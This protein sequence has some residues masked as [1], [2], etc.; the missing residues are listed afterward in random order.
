MRVSINSLP[1]RSTYL[2]SQVAGNNRP[3]YPKVDH[4]WLKVAHNNYEP[5]ALQVFFSGNLLMWLLGRRRWQLPET[6]MF[7]RSSGPRPRLGATR[8][9]PRLIMRK[10]K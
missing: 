10:P 6:L 4:Y 3:L 1:K 2:D 9:R 8:A 7:L 5:L